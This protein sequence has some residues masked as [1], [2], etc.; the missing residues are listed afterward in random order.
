MSY[1]HGSRGEDVSL[2]GTKIGEIV[3]Q[4][5]EVLTAKMQRQLDMETIFFPNIQQQAA[6]FARQMREANMP[7]DR[8]A[9]S[10]SRRVTQ[11]VMWWNESRSQ[12][13]RVNLPMWVVSLGKDLA[14]NELGAATGSGNTHFNTS[15]AVTPS[16]EFI[17]VDAFTDDTA[18]QG[19][20]KIFSSHM[21]NS[22]PSENLNLLFGKYAESATPLEKIASG[23]GELLVKSATYYA[24]LNRRTDLELNRTYGPT[25]IVDGK[26]VLVNLEGWK[27]E[28]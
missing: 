25:Q 23:V 1:E 9:A 11:K 27:A 22:R 16:G 7:V 14:S 20:K 5:N 13:I 24:T 26:S 6:T 18:K 19:D 28:K 8:V 15:V 21:I 10:Y 12:S 3:L 4:S 17:I 2:L